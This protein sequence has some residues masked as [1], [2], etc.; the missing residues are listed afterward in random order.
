MSFSLTGKRIL[1][2]GGSRGIGAE[3]TK[4]AAAQNAKFIAI[5]YVSDS[6]KKVAEEMIAKLKT[7][8]T[9]TEIVAVQ[10][11][12]VDQKTCS[13]F[14]K[15]ALQSAPEGKFDALVCSAG[16]M[17]MVTLAQSTDENFDY[18]YSGFSSPTFLFSLERKEGCLW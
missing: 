5:G 3:I 7:E 18:H 15:S 14:V 17:N 8:Y 6:S 11:D 13:E 2:T 4:A 9:N 12:L 1:I 10:G 16:V